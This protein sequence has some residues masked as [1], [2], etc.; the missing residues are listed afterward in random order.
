MSGDGAQNQGIC[1]GGRKTA[2]NRI[3][4]FLHYSVF[5]CAKQYQFV[6][7]SKIFAKTGGKLCAVPNFGNYRA[8][9]SKDVEAFGKTKE[10]YSN[11]R[12]FAMISLH[13]A[14]FFS[15]CS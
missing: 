15:R 9:P 10:K 11:L 14:Y 13:F 5:S 3:L 12:N 8:I 7:A 1:I 2:I 4:R 6:N